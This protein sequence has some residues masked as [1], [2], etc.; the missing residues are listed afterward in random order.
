MDPWGVGSQPQ[1]G[2]RSGTPNS[3]RMLCSTS[4]TYGTNMPRA[5]CLGE[6]TSSVAPTGAGV[7]PKTIRSF[8]HGL[9]VGQLP[10][11]LPGRDRALTRA[12]YGS[13]TMFEEGFWN[14]S[15]GNSARKKSR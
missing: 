1:R 13:S 2:G 11:P 10:P 9:A 4:K 5:L 14:S 3:G 7:E 6:P 12:A 15:S 8:S